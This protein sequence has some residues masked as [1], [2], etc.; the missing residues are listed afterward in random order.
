MGVPVVHAADGYRLMEGSQVRPAMLSEQ[1]SAMLRLVL[2][3][4][5][6]R[7]NPELRRRLD[8]L[9]Q[10]LTA[11]AGPGGG[12]PLHLAGSDRSGSL[13]PGVLSALE[14]AIGKTSA[15]E[16][17][18]VSLTS[19]KRARRGVD[20]WAV[21]H[22]ADAWYLIGR[23][24]RHDAPRMFRVDRIARVHQRDERFEYPEDFNLARALRGAWSLYFG[25][26][27]QEVVIHFDRSLAPLIGNARHHDDEEVSRLPGGDL[28]YR[29][30][31]AHLD[32]IARWIVTFGGKARAVAPPALI[33]MVSDIARGA[34]QEHAASPRSRAA[35]TARRT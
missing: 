30:P 31:L 7:R 22:R 23:C 21:F 1:E 11:S 26:P 25:E 24:H 27:L 20:P 16:I 17:D 14:T 2:D 8:T 9:S 13:A 18:Y 33:E 19:G 6:A 32:E 4:P 15:V 29:V 28:E 12:R 34:A 35:K 3:N 10:K 5:V